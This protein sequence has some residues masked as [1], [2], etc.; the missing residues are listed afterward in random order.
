MEFRD[1]TGQLVRTKSMPLFTTPQV[2]ESNQLFHCTCSG[3]AKI[4][5]DDLVLHACH[6]KYAP[7]TSYY[8]G[9]PKFIQYNRVQINPKL[10]DGELKYNW[11]IHYES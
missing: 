7:G 4:I 3:L 11:F 2:A 9:I 10:T 5:S 8:D 1:S 6:N